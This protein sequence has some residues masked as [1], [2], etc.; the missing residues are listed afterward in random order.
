MT[1]HRGQLET[2]AAVPAARARMAQ[3][4]VHPPSGR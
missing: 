3:V 2:R 4:P 1:L